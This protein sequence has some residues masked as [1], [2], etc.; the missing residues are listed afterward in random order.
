MSKHRAADD[1]IGGL[2][3]RIEEIARRAALERAVPPEPQLAEVHQHIAEIA[4]M[5]RQSLAVMAELQRVAEER[6]A[7]QFALLDAQA[8]RADAAVATAEE[9][10]ATLRTTGAALLT[11]VQEARDDF[12][13]STGILTGAQA[14]LEAG[15]RRVQTSGDALVRYLDDRDLALEAERD[16]I[17]RDV[18]EDFAASLD[19]RERRGI[20]KRLVGVV[21]RRR[22]ARDAAR[23]RRE[24][25]V[26]GG[27]EPG[28]TTGRDERI[29]LAGGGGP[30]VIDL[31][32]A[33]Q[34]RRTTPRR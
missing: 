23:W 2:A 9:A 12:R 22:D 7:A 10:R 29:A 20:A 5:V 4:G 11:Q 30:V 34:A 19:A 18:L 21:D 27:Q 31:D 24:H 17:L 15:V 13:G 33:A 25:G 32:A 16:R 8:R 6:Y 26:D 14:V 1:S 3:D 28:A